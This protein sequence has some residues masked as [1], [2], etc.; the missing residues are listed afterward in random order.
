VNLRGT[1][2]VAKGRG[3][4]GTAD[5]EEDPAEDTEESTESGLNLEGGAAIEDDM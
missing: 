2:P 3:A 1:G 4:E 5:K